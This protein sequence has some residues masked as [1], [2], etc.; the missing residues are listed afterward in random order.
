[1]RLLR[2]TNG[3]RLLVLVVVPYVVTV[4][5]SE[6]WER[7]E[8]PVLQRY[9]ISAHKHKAAAHSTLRT[10]AMYLLEGCVSGHPELRS[11]FLFLCTFRAVS[12]PMGFSSLRLFIQVKERKA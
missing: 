2:W 12:T 6:Q 7:V 8:K 3:S 4:R 5:R 1:M 11:F 9:I 10:A